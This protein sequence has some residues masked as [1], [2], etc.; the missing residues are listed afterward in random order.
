M[1][2][3]SP[4]AL[5][6][7]AIVTTVGA[8]G[9]RS[10]P[11][12]P[13]ESAPPPPSPREDPA[14]SAADGDQSNTTPTRPAATPDTLPQPPIEPEANIPVGAETPLRPPIA[15]G[16]SATTTPAGQ[17]RAETIRLGSW[18]LRRL[19]HGK[20]RLDLVAQLITSEFDAVAL[21]EVMSPDGVNDLLALL[22]GWKAAISPRAVGTAGYAEYYAVLYDGDKLRPST[23]YLLDDP[24][25]EFVRE[26]FV[27]C[28]AARVIDFC[29]VSIHVVYGKTVGPRDAEI[30][31]LGRR[32]DG[33]RAASKEKDW[34]LVGDFNR[35]DGSK[36]W[37]DL[38]ALGFV[39]AFRDR[40]TT[41]GKKGY[42]NTYDH[43]LAD[44]TH[45]HELRQGSALDMIGIL[46][47]GV[48]ESCIRDVSDH[49]PIEVRLTA[50]RDD[51]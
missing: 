2:L 50:D 20:K 3:R 49:A 37:T 1:E 29:V 48:I 41:I 12:R 38:A 39:L 21:Q 24:A 6:A 28:L 44:P 9:P 7:L 45:T 36:A 31:A 16:D 34:I 4:V 33:L 11:A 51:D 35:P 30:R 14:P 32:A 13:T 26:P 22:P 10:Q 43:A 23:S 5:I 25:D 40:P 18:N 19:G 15:P 8:C 42:V 46:C 17:R 47:A 27:V